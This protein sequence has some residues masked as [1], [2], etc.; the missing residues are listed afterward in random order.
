MMIQTAPLAI[1]LMLAAIPLSAA[2]NL[3]VMTWNISGGE[4]S[5]AN[6]ESNAHA[7]TQQLGPVDIAIIEEVIETDQVAAIAKGLGLDHW[8]ISDF[9]PPVSIS[10]FWANSLE[11]AVISRRPFE[12]VAEWDTTGRNL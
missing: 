3:R 8:V 7:A 5:A 1:A 4:Q 2:E 11:V 12:R 6:L 10:G 9:S